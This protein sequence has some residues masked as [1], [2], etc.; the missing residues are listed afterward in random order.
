[1]HLQWAKDNDFMLEA[2]DAINDHSDAL[3]LL[4][5]HIM[6]VKSDMEKLTAHVAGNDAD[7]RERL[8]YLEVRSRRKVLRPSYWD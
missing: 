3:K 1:M 8:K 2:H 6:G 4:K 7:L 5:A